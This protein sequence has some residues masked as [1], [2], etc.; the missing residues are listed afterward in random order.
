MTDGTKVEG[1]A[2]DLSVTGMSAFV[3]KPIGIG[4]PVTVRVRL[5]GTSDTA[6]IEATVRWTKGNN[7]IGLQ[8]GMLRA[9]ETHAIT[10]ILAQARKAEADAQG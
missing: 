6:E 1:V 7:A 5:P 9:A 8:F 4:T 10:Q 3:P 2:S